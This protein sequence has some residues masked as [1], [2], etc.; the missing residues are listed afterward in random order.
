VAA[1]AVLLAT[2]TSWGQVEVE[3]DLTLLVVSPEAGPAQVA[4]SYPRVV[5]HNELSAGIAELARATGAVVSQ[6]EIVDGPLARGSSQEGTAGEFAAAGLIRRQTGALPLGPL[7]RALPDWHRARLVFVVPGK[8][9]LVG[10]RDTTA[11]GFLV[12]LVNDMQ[13]YEY[14]VE[15]KS[16][17]SG[18]SAQATEASRRTGP[19]VSVA[20][21]GLPAGFLVGW[22]LG[23]RRTGPTGSTRR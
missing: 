11:D 2:G 10:P 16:V 12:R 3:Y 17:G 20:L 14:D 13:P 8:F 19:M 15:R 9:G 7:I 22:L 6:V 5:D 1:A 18:P 4:F 23:D 21:I